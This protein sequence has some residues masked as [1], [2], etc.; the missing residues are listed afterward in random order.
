MLIPVSE[1]VKTKM[2]VAAGGASFV[3]IFKIVPWP[4]LA[5]A[6]ACLYWLVRIIERGWD[7]FKKK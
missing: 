3:A 2:D 1:A 6:L 7:R 4:E 5:G